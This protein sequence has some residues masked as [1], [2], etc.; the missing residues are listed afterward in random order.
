MRH[1][2]VTSPRLSTLALLGLVTFTG[3]QSAEPE[4]S[5]ADLYSKGQYVEASAMAKE[6]ADDAPDNAEASAVRDMT[7]VA[8]LLEVGR[9]A[10]YASDLSLALKYFFQADSIRPGHPVVA[11]WIEKTIGELADRSM[12]DAGEAAA[13]GDLQLATTHYERALV[14]QPELDIAREGLARMLLLENY[15]EGMGEAYYKK[16]VR[17]MRAFWLGQANAD[18]EYNGKYDPEGVEGEMRREQVAKLMAE[19]RMLMA[20]RFEEEGLINAARNEYRM[21]LLLVPEFGLAKD[22]LALVEVEVEAADTLREAERKTMRG[23]LDAAEELLREGAKLSEKQQDEYRA[24]FNEVEEV[25]WRRLY[26][27]GLDYELDFDFESAVLKYDELLQDASFYEDALARRKTCHGFVE[28]AVRLYA[29]AKSADSA[30]KK[31]NKYQQI[32]T[33]WPEYLDV[34]ENILLLGGVE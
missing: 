13:T 16:G 31:I 2:S 27:E 21:A 29:E 18:F 33:F 4:A 7:N 19:D 26:D 14:F 9:E 23:E 30:K 32:A 3:C 10:S 34:E 15:R 8:E 12:I 24:A 17:A 25:R 28:L 11:K 22:A 6:L 1:T 20:K 5:V